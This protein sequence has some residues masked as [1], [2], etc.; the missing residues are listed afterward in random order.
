VTNKGNITAEV[1]R[2]PFD[3]GGQPELSTGQPLELSFFAWNVRS[4]LSATKAVL[5][6]EE[7]YCNSWHWPTASK[8]LAEADRI[9]FDH[10]VQYG[11]WSGYGGASRWNE[12]GLD[13][14]TAC[15]ASA[16]VTERMGLFSTVHVGY[17]F[18]P[19]H[20]AK[21]G[22]CIDF[23]SGGRFGLNIV[24]GANVNDFRLFGIKERPPSAVRYDQADEFVTLLKH[25][26]ANDAP[27][28]FEGDH[29]QC[30]GGYVAP[31]PVRRPRPILMNAG[32]SDA[33][34]DF[35]CRQADWVFV[36]P[37]TGR[38]EDYADLV[39]KAHRLAAKYG[40]QV[41]VGAMCYAVI[42]ENDTE[43]ARVVE[44]LESEA[45]H[46]AIRNYIRAVMGTSNEMAIEDESDPHCGLGVDQ[47]NKVALGMTG[48]QLFGGYET[49][50]ERMREM[51]AVGVDNLVIGFFD[52]QRALQQMEEHVIP[53]L[54]RMGLRH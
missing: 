6:D 8:L 37:P 50:A 46:E 52:P 33:G 53:I 49:V 47:F 54:K 39:E 2:G 30:Y 27:V 40:R 16:M 10:Q 38:L 1:L 11:M 43:A 26:W 12:E 34:F 23:V 32:Q 36:V 18:H 31:K 7:R 25:L 45:D 21:L 20:I 17:H 42:E 15:T 22:A 28:D 41:K 44:W 3:P 13:F 51:H 9:G 14:A 19:M 35:A 5:S 29:Y 48:Y 4:G 24:T